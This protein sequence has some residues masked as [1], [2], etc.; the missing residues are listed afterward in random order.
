MG[1]DVADAQMPAGDVQ[2]ERDAGAFA[3]EREFWL[4]AGLG[5]DFHVGPCYAAAPAG[6]EDFEDRFLGRET[7]REML[8]IALRVLPAVLLL[9][10]REA[11]VEK[12][13]PVLLDKLSNPMGL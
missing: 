3:G 12:M 13:L 7:A 6:A 2:L 8:E 10:R 1:F 5:E 9:A 11:A 4:A